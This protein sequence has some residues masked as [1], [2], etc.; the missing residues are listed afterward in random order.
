M[1]RP[2]PFGD[3]LYSVTGGEPMPTWNRHRGH[4]G[5]DGRRKPGGEWDYIRGLSLRTRRQLTGAGY[6]AKHA[7]QPDVFAGLIRERAPGM[8]DRTDTEC[9][10]WYVV[11]ALEALAERR[12]ANGYDR[13]LRLA[14]RRGAPSYYALRGE[15][16]KAAGYPSYWAMRKAKGW[17]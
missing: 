1:Y 17:V 14:R 4:V 11:H 6:M 12:R 3:L 13:K 10:V 2:T 8:S 16:A 9:L 5:M 7:M 15:E